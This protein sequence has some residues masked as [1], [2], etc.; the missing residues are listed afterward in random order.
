LEVTAGKKQNVREYDSANA[1]RG[2]IGA[3]DMMAM[4]IKGEETTA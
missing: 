4:E 1:A 2:A 3:I